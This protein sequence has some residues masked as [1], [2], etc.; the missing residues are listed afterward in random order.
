MSRRGD[1]I[2][3]RKDGRWEGRYKNGYKADGSVKYRSVYALTYTECKNKLEQAKAAP[4]QSPPM[5]KELCFSQVLSLWMD[6]N[7]VRLKG[8]T[9]SKYQNVIQTHILSALGGLKISQMNSV[10]V[11]TFLDKKIRAGGIA[12]GKPLSASYVRTMAI[13]IE[14]SLKFAAAEGWCSPLKT[15]IHKPVLSKK[16][17]TVFSKE[18][19]CALLSVLLQEQSGT[20]LGTMIALCTGMRIGEICALRWCDVDLKS[21]VIHVKQTISRVNSND[22]D[23]KTKLILDTPKTLSSQ[24]DL[25]VSAAL[26]SML[27]TAYQKRSS[28]FVVSRDEHFVGTRTFDHQYRNML[29]K[30]GLPVI[31]FHALRHTFATRCAQTGMD[32]KALSQLLGHANANISLNTYVHPSL[33]TVKLQI[34]QLYNVG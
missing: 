21:G 1:N 14:A 7:R 33:D 9:Q 2:H 12:D 8:A 22:T 23:Q 29:R 4:I 32:A 15:P 5:R 24:R 25:P 6:Y 34:E 31:H 17:P 13:I 16:S 19:E 18:E 26:K 20:A 11:N 30:H 10:I 3:K 27:E 28:Q